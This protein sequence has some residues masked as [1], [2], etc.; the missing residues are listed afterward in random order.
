MCIYMLKN[1]G[2]V[3]RTSRLSPR[4]GYPKMPCLRLGLLKHCLELT[5]ILDPLFYLP[6]SLVKPMCIN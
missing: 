2:P 1:L 3:R 4:W 5:K 6:K